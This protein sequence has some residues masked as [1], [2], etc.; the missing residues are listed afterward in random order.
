MSNGLST[1]SFMTGLADGV[2]MGNNLHDRKRQQKREDRADAMAEEDRQRQIGLADYQMSRQ[3]L[4][5]S[6]T[7]E[8]YDQDRLRQSAEQDLRAAYQTGQLPPD[9][10]KKY[11]ALGLDRMTDQQWLA[12]RQQTGLQLETAFKSG[13]FGSKESISALNSMLADELAARETKDGLKRSVSA[14]REIKGTGNL[15]VELSVTGKDGKPYKA[16]LTKNGTAGGDD[17]VIQITPGKV[18]E[19]IDATQNQAE[20]A[21]MV[22]QAG[23]DPRKLADA[24]H[25]ILT[26]KRLSSSPEYSFERGY[27]S[28]GREQLF[29]VDKKTGSYRPIGGAKAIV[30]KSKSGS[31]TSHPDK[32]L[33]DALAQVQKDAAMD[34]DGAA[35]AFE[36]SMGIPLEMV[37]S[38][39]R[40]KRDSGQTDPI[41]F[42]ELSAYVAMREASLSAASQPEPQ[43]V[44]PERTPPP[45]AKAKSDSLGS[46]NSTES[47]NDIAGF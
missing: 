25:F 11:Q 23:G 43:P 2:N 1:A 28:A 41:T 32:M 24:T 19:W 7:D 3:R 8:K 45:Q 26:G 37:M 36:Q 27:N 13:S 34:P 42:S 22:Q 40:A 12:K 20:I 4:A 39:Q 35:V 30:D 46:L 16:P 38:A 18:G 10:F 14:V 31:K 33:R 5:D 15:A 29:Q 9:F 6:R 44:K 17:T 47:I 21:H